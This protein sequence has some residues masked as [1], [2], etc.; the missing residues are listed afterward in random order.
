MIKNKITNPLKYHGGKYYLAMLIIQLMP[1]HRHF[2]EAFFGSGAVM[3]RKDPIGVS[4]V[5]N[6]VHS[7]LITFWRVLQNPEWFER[8][9][10]LC[11]ATPFSQMDWEEC[12]QRLHDE[13]PVVR[14]HALF[15]LNRQSRQGLMT[16]FATLSRNRVR[17]SM[18][19]Q[20]SSWL[21]AIDGL[22][23]VHERLKRVVILNKDAIEV[24]QQQDGEHTL[25]YLDPPYVQSTRVAR[26]AY[27][28]EMS[29]KDHHQLVDVILNCEG[30]VMLSG[31]PNDIY[32]R[33]EAAGWETFDFQL[34][35]SS[36][37]QKSKPKATERVWANFE[38]NRDALEA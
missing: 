1:L 25:H 9:V 26:S 22:P 33:L 11:E 23:E 35:K 17:R 31:Y 3:F 4:E 6:D 37:S 20:V 12:Q 27:T 29:D 18:N 21:T 5:A 19:E 7:T 14:A 2:V 8:F 10:R 15:V 34:T 36:S 28:H 32:E 38:L 13:D 24:I 30:K 16:D